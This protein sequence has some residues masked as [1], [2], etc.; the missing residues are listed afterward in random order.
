VRLNK[1]QLERNEI[2]YFVVS[3]GE[4]KSGDVHT[5]VEHLDEAVNIP[6]GR[7]EGADD[8]SLALLDIS[9][10]ENGVKLDSV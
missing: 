7:A 9:G 10:I 4:V 8:F 3:V 5:G 6:A 1:F 2:T